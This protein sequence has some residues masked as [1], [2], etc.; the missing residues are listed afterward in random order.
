MRMYRGVLVGVRVGVLEELGEFGTDLEGGLEGG[1]GEEED[2]GGAGPH[3][4]IYNWG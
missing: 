3:W 1:L 4:L 2:E